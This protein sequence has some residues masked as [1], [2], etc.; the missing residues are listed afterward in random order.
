YAAGFSS[1]ARSVNRITLLRTKHDLGASR[2]DTPGSGVL[3]YTRSDN[4]IFRQ[5]NLELSAFTVEP[6]IWYVDSGLAGGRVK[7]GYPDGSAG[8]VDVQLALRV[9]PSVA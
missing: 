9:R 7:T 3:T 1:I 6:G 8:L 4:C 2:N 5:F